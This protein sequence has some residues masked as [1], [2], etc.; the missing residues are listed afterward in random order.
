MLNIYSKTLAMQFSQACAAGLSYQ[1]TANQEK[2]VKRAFLL[3]LMV[4]LGLLAT[5]AFAQAAPETLDTAGTGIK[6]RIVVF[7]GGTGGKVIAGICFLIG[8]FRTMATQSAPPILIGG[9]IALIA[10]GIAPTFGAFSA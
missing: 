6:D 3:A 2:F 1:L 4:F 5:G 7:F 10:L 8:F 9:L